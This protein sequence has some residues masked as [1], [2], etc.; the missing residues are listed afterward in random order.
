MKCSERFQK[1]LQVGFSINIYLTQ[2]LTWFESNSIKM[3]CD[4]SFSLV[5]KSSCLISAH[6]ENTCFRADSSAEDGSH[7]TDSKIKLRF[8][9]D[10]KR[11]QVR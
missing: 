2:L 3:I 11:S 10:E 7:F 9:V 8:S 1:H 5:L 6:R 4:V